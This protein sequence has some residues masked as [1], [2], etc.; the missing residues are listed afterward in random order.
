MILRVFTLIEPAAK[1]GT[2]V[3]ARAIGGCYVA[4]PELVVHGASNAVGGAVLV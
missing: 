3:K 2:T 4:R 1:T